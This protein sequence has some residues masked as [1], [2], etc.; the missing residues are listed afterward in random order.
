MG[1]QYGKDEKINKS[2]MKRQE[3]QKLIEIIR[4]WRINTKGKNRIK[5]LNIKVKQR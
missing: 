3:Q 2:K 5:N 1:Q 4:I